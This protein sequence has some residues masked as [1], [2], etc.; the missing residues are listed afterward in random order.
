MVIG[1][2]ALPPGAPLRLAVRACADPLAWRW[3]CWLQ[4][5]LVACSP[6]D[7]VDWRV[8]YQA[9]NLVK[10]GRSAAGMTLSEARALLRRLD[11]HS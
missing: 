1:A 7:D 4:H 6:D 2:A 10:A 8:V 9:C 5:G 3:C 11:G